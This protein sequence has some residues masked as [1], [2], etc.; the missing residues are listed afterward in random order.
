MKDYKK[1]LETLRK[2]AAEADLIR[3]LATSPHKREMFT[4]LAEHLHTLAAELEQEIA[5]EMA[6]GQSD[7]AVSSWTA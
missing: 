5:R 6:R 1:H 2:Q 7:A 4:K 3:D